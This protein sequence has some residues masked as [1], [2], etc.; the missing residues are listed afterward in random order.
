MGILE[1]QFIGDFTDGFIGGA[2]KLL[3]FVH[4]LEQDILLGRFS[5]LFLDEIPEIVGGEMQFICEILHI[6]QPLF[7]R[8][9]SFEVGIQQAFELRQHIPVH[10]L[11]GDELAVVKTH[12]VVQKD[13][14]IGRHDGLGVPVNATSQFRP[15]FRQAVQEQMPFPLRH[16]EGLGSVIG[17]KGIIPHLAPQGSAAEQIGM[18]Q[19]RV[20]FYPEIFPVVII[21]QHLAGRHEDKSALLV[22]II[23]PSIP[24]VSAFHIFQENGIKPVG[25]ADM[26][27]RRD[28]GKINNADQRGSVS[29]PKKEL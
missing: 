4:Q 14:Y 25:L 12:S 28:L 13:F 20:P 26:P 22:I 8:L 1:P 5:R 29:C 23:M 10:M 15:D 2:E 21:A 17:K 9:V 11:A 24:Q 3:G 16:M 19:E 27:Q 7:L 6:G 18:E